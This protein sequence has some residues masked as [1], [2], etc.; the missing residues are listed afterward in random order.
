MDATQDRAELKRDFETALEA[1]LQH[2][3]EN[4]FAIRV[5]TRPQLPLAMGRYVLVGTVS[6]W[7]AAQRSQP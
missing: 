3:K 7:P 6:E 5:E 2:A 4:G 1:L